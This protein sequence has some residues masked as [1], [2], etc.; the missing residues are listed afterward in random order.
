[1]LGISVVIPTYNRAD[2]I[3]ETLDALFAQT[4]VPDEVIVVDD[5]SQ[6]S[7]PAVLASYGARLKTLRIRNSGELVAR[8]IGL[9]LARGHLVAFCDNDDLWL[10]DFLAAMSAQWRTEP[11]LLACYSDFSILRGSTVSARSK[12]E[13]APAGYWSDLR[14]AGPDSGMFDHA[15]A[16]RLLAFQPF[17]PS[18]MMVH[19]DAFAAAGGWDET[20]GIGSD[21]ATVL[22]VAARPPIGVVRRPL[23]HI[24]KHADNYSGDTEQTNLRDARVLDHVLATRPELAP[25]AAVI[26]ASAAERRAAALDSAFTRGDF[27]A[28][29]AI[30]RL[31]PRGA[32]TPRQVVKCAIAGLPPG[33]ARAAASIA[34]R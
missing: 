24:R 6:D 29:N 25:L 21:F 5:G 1:M 27:A 23:V 31:L 3:R 20:V 19:R 11:G 7:T 2:M 16:E 8:N 33:L 4:R 32:R 14:A 9:G 18:C 10:P 15:I 30:R 17:F 28:V 34:S 13:D 26:R 22:R 12:F